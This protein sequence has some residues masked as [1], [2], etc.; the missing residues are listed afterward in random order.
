[1]IVPAGQSVEPGQTVDVS[2]GMTAPM[3]VGY[4][5]SYWGLKGRDAQWMPISHGADGNS[6]FVKIR[7]SDSGVS[8]LPGARIVEQHIDIELEQGSGEACTP[9]ATYLVHAYIRADG[10]LSALYEIDSTAGQIAAGSFIDPGSGA[11][12]TTVEGTVKFDAA[13]F[14][15][16]GA[17]IVPIKLRFVGPYPYPRDITVNFWVDGGQWV[18]TKV[19]CP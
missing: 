14:A 12:V 7:V 2:V 10:P 18:S 16:D 4:Y 15:A 19:A 13:L 3:E 5:T 8:G 9:E 11:K 1:M 6:F 17:P